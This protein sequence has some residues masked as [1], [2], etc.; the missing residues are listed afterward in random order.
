MY[1][2]CTHQ[3]YDIVLFVNITFQKFILF[4]LLVF[5]VTN[6]YA[7]AVSTSNLMS[8]DCMT[9]MMDTDDSASGIECECSMCDS[10]C[11][12]CNTDAASP[13]SLIFVVTNSKLFIQKREVHYQEFTDTLNNTALK[14]STPPPII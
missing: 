11:L 10:Q 4:S 1:E 8:A 13:T 2:N 9:Q 5:F 6:S 3:I 12:H 7:Y 14:L